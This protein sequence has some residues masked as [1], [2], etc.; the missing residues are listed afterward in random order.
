MAQGDKNSKLR[1][2]VALLANFAGQKEPP[3]V[4]GNAARPRAFGCINVETMYN[5]FW[6]SNKKSWM[7][8]TLF[9]EVL[10]RFDRKM[11]LEIMPH[12]TQT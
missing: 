9:T 2:T 5:V 1:L 4:I 11:V 6:R 10:K 3:I 7:T 12:L 8:T